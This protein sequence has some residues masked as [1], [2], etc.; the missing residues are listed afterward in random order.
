MVLKLTDINYCVSMS[1]IIVYKRPCGWERFWVNTPSLIYLSWKHRRQKQSG[2]FPWT[3][4]G[5]AIITLA[6]GFKFP[7]ARLSLGIDFQM[8]TTY[9]PLCTQCI[10]SW[11]AHSRSPLTPRPHAHPSHSADFCHSMHWESITTEI[12][13]HTPYIPPHTDTMCMYMYRLTATNKALVGFE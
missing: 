12:S 7:R 11:Q 6:H 1:Y 9:F 3:P 5:S 10:M 2:S 4:L 8:K 13:I